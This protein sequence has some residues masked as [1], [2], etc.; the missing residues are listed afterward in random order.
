MDIR[1]EL[2]GGLRHRVDDDELVVSV[3]ANTP[4]VGDVVDAMETQYSQLEGVL[5]RVARA[6]DD[7]IVGD[8]HRLRSDSTMALLP[9]VSGGSG[10]DPSKYLSD[11][12]LDRR[13]LIEETADERCGALVVF[14]GDIRDH[15]AGRDDVVAIDYE[16]HRTMA[17]RELEAVEREVVEQFDVLQCRIQHRTGRVEVGESSV[18]VVCRAPHRDAAFQGARYGIDELKKRTPLWKKECYANGEHRYL[19]GTSI[20]QD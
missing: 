19:D 2:Y 6:V 7:E 5:D 10:V 4:T 15:N 20:R 9:P 8:D 3:D 12:P 17:A 1:V 18:L 13:Q 11:R 16:A 14:S